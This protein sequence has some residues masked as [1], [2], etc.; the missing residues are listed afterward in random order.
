M[1]RMRLLFL[2]KKRCLQHKI[3]SFLI[4]FFI[5]K[6]QLSSNK[7]RTALNLVLYFPNV[8]V[9][10]AWR[11]YVHTLW[12]SFGSNHEIMLQISLD[13]LTLKFIEQLTTV[14]HL[15]K[16]HH[17]SLVL[18][19]VLLRNWLLRLTKSLSKRGSFL[20]YEEASK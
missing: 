19:L 17:M 3:I 12:V 20:W 18:L 1:K 10:P 7:I 11:I 16:Y 2:E 14:R 9:T 6:Y 4:L 5:G 8:P 13:I 15:I